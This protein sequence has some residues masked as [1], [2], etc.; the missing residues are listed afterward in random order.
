MSV[1]EMKFIMAFL[2]SFSGYFNYTLKTFFSTGTKMLNDESACESADGL[3]LRYHTTT[4]LYTLKELTKTST[5]TVDLQG[6]DSEY[7]GHGKTLCPNFL[8]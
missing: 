5:R 3:F 7:T 2:Y 1:T 4:L 6:K 8:R